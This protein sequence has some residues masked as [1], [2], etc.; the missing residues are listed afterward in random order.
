MDLLWLTLATAAF[1]GTH[2]ALSNA[3]RGPLVR[4]LGAGG[5]QALYS[6]VAL[7]TLVMAVR[8][9]NAA[10]RGWE[11]WDGHAALPWALSSVMTWLALALVLASLVGNPA[12]PGVQLDGLSARVPQG[13]FRLTRHPMMMGIALWALAHVLVAPTARTAILMGGMIVLALGG[14][15][16]QDRKK[17]A[18]S[19]REWRSWTHRTSFWPDPAAA[20]SL[21]VPLA[22]AAL[23]WFGATL[24]H[25]WLIGEPAGLWAL[26][27]PIHF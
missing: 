26:F 27:P 16:L 13:I 10:P 21:L 7:A 23:P 20:D 2:F 4:G 11:L 8:A 12:L 1:V 15:A 6:L 9:F 17:I 3:V 14:A 25:L 24:L 18:L 5:F 22:I 19:G